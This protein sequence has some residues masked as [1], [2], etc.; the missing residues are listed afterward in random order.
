MLPKYKC[1]SNSELTNNRVKLGLFSS[2]GRQVQ[3]DAKG[4]RGGEVR[5][6]LLQLRGVP[7]EG[8]AD[9]R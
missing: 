1:L 4:E 8:E 5:R 2:S 7:H 9:P 6:P 3:Q